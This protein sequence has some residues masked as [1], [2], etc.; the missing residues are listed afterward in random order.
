MSQRFPLRRSL[1][2]SA[3]LLALS[4]AAFAVEFIFS[5]GDFLPGVTA[6]SPLLAGDVLQINTGSFKFFNAVTFT[7]QTGTV[8]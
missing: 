8:N 7:N 2:G 3:A 1:L 6:P 4:P 5:S